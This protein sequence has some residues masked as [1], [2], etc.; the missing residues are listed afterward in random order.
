MIC[1]YV[2][3]CV[4]FVGQTWE[5][6]FA[7]PCAPRIEGSAGGLV[8]FLDFFVFLGLLLKKLCE[9]GLE[10]RKFRRCM[11]QCLCPCWKIKIFKQHTELL[12]QHFARSHC[13]HGMLALRGRRNSPD[14]VEIS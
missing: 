14:T 3:V 8:V 10:V 6:F 11:T 2:S 12:Y 13:G 7:M 1:V 5:L 4:H 9:G